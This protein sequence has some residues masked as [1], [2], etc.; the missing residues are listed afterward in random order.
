M[1]RCTRLGRNRDTKRF[2]GMNMNS[3]KETTSITG[4]DEIVPSAYI[5]MLA[6]PKYVRCYQTFTVQDTATSWSDSEWDLCD[7]NA[8][9]ILALDDIT[10]GL[11]E[12]ELRDTQ[13]LCFKDYIK[14]GASRLR[15]NVVSAIFAAQ[16][17]ITKLSTEYINP[18]VELLHQRAMIIEQSVLPPSPSLIMPREKVHLTSLI[19]PSGA[20]LAWLQMDDIS[21]YG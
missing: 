1:E 4:Q 20:L 3:Y 6:H 21:S 14:L 5:K 15:S 7:P 16:V 11:S 12:A 13:K 18:T 19:A 2:K 9:D 17:D 8:S 10:G